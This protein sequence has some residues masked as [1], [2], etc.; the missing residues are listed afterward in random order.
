MYRPFT[1]LST[2]LCVTA[3]FCY[4]NYLFLITILIL[5]LFLAGAVQIFFLKHL[6]SNSFYH[7]PPLSLKNNNIGVVGSLWGDQQGRSAW[8]RL[9]LSIKNKFCAQKWM[10]PSKAILDYF[11]N[12]F[13]SI[14]SCVLVQLYKLLVPYL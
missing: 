2:R 14:G 9:F 10:A 1:Y 8:A 4:Y 3:L 6:L 7:N 11:F 12:I 13:I 5:A